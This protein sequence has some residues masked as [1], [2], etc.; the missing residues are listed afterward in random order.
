MVPPA[1]ANP[2]II[3]E[4]QFFKAVD[5]DVKLMILKVMTII[6]LDSACITLMG[7]HLFRV[8]CI[9]HLNSQ[10]PLIPNFFLQAEPLQAALCSFKC[11]GCRTHIFTYF[12]EIQK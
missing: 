4:T 10:I 6:I 8:M 3:P 7:I 5:Q 2:V 1:D 9:P 11:T 12:T